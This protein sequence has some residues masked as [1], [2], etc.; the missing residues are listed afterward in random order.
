MMIVQYEV[1]SSYAV[2]YITRLQHYNIRHIK[3]KIRKLVS[4]DDAIDFE[5][6]NV[7]TMPG[8]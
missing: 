8:T 7:F 3:I 4:L 6:N 1:F 2:V 5:K